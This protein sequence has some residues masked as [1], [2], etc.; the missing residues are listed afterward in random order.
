MSPL[1]GCRGEAPAALSQFRAD[2]YACLPSRSD[3]L[4]ELTGA[5]LCTERLVKTRVGLALAPV[6][7]RGHGALCGGLNQ[8]RIF[9]R[10]HRALAGLPSPR[11]ADGW[12]V[13]AVDVSP[14][15]RPD[16]ATCPDRSF[17]YTHGR[18][19]PTW[20]PAS[21][22]RGRTEPSSPL[23]HLTPAMITTGPAA[24]WEGAEG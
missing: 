8:G 13:L 7:R 4:F 1:T 23:C 19:V 15:L 17:C 2:F 18:S 12:L 5:L 16:A 10:L 14:W 11:A 3:A 20:C 21:R 9:G 6:H 22:D 24:S